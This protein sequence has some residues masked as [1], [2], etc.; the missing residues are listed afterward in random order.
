MHK[1]HARFHVLI[2]STYFG[3]HSA[4]CIY[5]VDVPIEKTD[6]HNDDLLKMWDEVVENQY[7]LGNDSDIPRLR[8][9]DI[10]IKEMHLLYVDEISEKKR[11]LE[12]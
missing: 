12:F 7:I 10:G 8:V 5:Y 9:G 11:V 1:C 4:Y 3:D 6:N 2:K